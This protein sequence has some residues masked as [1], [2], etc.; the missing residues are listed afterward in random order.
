MCR[1]QSCTTYVASI[2]LSLCVLL[3]RQV[4]LVPLGATSSEHFEYKQL[5]PD[6]VVDGEDPALEA[7]VPGFGVYAK[8]PIPA[9]T[10][11]AKLQGEWVRAQLG[12]KKRKPAGKKSVAA[13]KKRKPAGSSRAP[14]RLAVPCFVV[15]CACSCA[16]NGLL[17]CW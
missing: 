4:D 11:F 9:N 12:G 6:P 7:A 13:S 16:R 3:C 15:S 14:R 10:F 2:E 8:T 17:R 1:N 5:G